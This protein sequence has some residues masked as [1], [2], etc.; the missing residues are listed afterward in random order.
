MAP[1]RFERFRPIVLCLFFCL[2]L[3]SVAGR[4]Q[5]TAAGAA[6]P[7]RFLAIQPVAAPDET[8]RDRPAARDANARDVRAA[9]GLADIA[10]TQMRYAEAFAVLRRLTPPDARADEA[11]PD[12]LNAL[13]ALYLAAEDFSRAEAA[14]RRLQDR[15]PDDPRAALGLAQVA[16][17]RQR[18]PECK[19]AIH[20]LLSRHPDFAL[21]HALL[22]QIHIEENQ[23]AEAARSAERAV[24]LAPNNPETLSALCSVR[25]MEK[26]PESVRALAQKILDLNPYN[27]RVRRILSQY[28]RSKKSRPV[29]SP[30]AQR[31]FRD[32]LA[33]ARRRDHL[34]AVAA[35]AAATEQD[36][37]FLEALLGLGAAAL[38]GGLADQAERAAE[39]AVRLDPDSPLAHL[40]LSL[41][42]LERHERA[43]RELGVA[44]AVPSADPEA[45]ATDAPPELGEVFVAADALSPAQRRTLWRSVAPFARFLPELK[46]RGAKHYLLALDQQL[47]DVPAYAGLADQITFDGRFYGSIRG[48]GGVVT[49]SGI[50]HLAAVERGGFN[51]IAHE[52]AHQV[53]ACALDA[54]TLARI[55]AL[56]AA[57]RRDGKTLDYY[58]AANEMEY[59]AQ[60]Y[61]AYVSRR[62]RPNLGPTGRHT[63]DELLRVDPDLYRLIDELARPP[64]APAPASASGR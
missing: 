39:R 43:R 55:Q 61:E 8:E 26:K 51:T 34:R 21:A 24:A 30:A 53:H 64:A 20:D 41:A 12:A 1:V 19:R 4:A 38:D 6:E 48:V 35:Y 31:A 49:V 54:K 14:Y 36:P 5:E 13:G 3:L 9:V 16:L 42:H 46:R 59:F 62:K 63:R 17:A 27:V 2:P 23:P 10:R 57:A 15:A 52:F 47:A 25:I 44:D 50:E 22:A 45:P 56:Y 32:G 18:Y 29:A 37:A 11:P 40:Q 33:A 60:G 7:N 28:V 58:A